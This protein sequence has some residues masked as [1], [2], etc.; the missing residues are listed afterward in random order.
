MGET[1]MATLSDIAKKCGVSTAAVSYVL[2]GQGDKR[3]ISRE[4]QDEIKVAAKELEYKASKIEH[5]R[6]NIRIGCFWPAKNLE[7]M[8]P[9]IIEGINLALQFETEPVDISIHPY[10]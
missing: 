6:K 5:K 2:N 3:R 9:N 1:K 7:T 4:V 10:E 8:I